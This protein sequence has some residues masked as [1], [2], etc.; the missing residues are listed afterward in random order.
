MM[1]EKIK[2]G[3]LIDSFIVP[4]W[5]YTTLEK[6]LACNFS[7]VVFVSIQGNAKAAKQKS[8]VNLY[9]NLE[10][11]LVKQKL[12][13]IT[14]FSC[15]SLIQNLPHRDLNSLIKNVHEI[16]ILINLGSTAIHTYNIDLPVWTF[17]RIPQFNANKIVQHLKKENGTYEILLKEFSKKN[18]SGKILYRSASADSIFLNR[19]INWALWKA[20]LFIPRKLKEIFETE[21]TD[22]SIETKES[23]DRKNIHTLQDQ[24]PLIFLLKHCF[25]VFNTTVKSVFTFEQ[26]I[27]LFDFFDKKKPPFQPAIFKELIPP[28][29]RFWADPSVFTTGDQHYY[30]FVEEE[31]YKEK[32]AHISVLEIYKAGNISE[33]RIV[34]DKPYHLSYPYVFK[35]G[36]DIYMLPETSENKTIELYRA[37]DFPYKWELKMNLMENVHAVDATIH[38]YNNKYWMFVNIREINGASDW[39]E[40]FLFYADELLTQNWKPHKQNPIVSDV[41]T[42]RPAGKI[43]E[44]E[45]KLYRPSQNSSRS[46]G[47]AININEITELSETTYAEKLVSTIAPWNKKIIATHT[48]SLSENL[49]VI[50]ARK[51][52]NR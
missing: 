27:L 10:R 52:R 15:E 8:L 18:P 34:L 16:D 35:D 26:W 2:L 41:R 44:L 40:L 49:C 30:I 4:A 32:K 5:I 45:G 12:S 1:R 28:K 42:A 13:A 46:Y 17:D 3:I 51:R 7:T 9:L 24:S 21:Q 37:N 43:F 25:R 47:Y 39:D 6:I 36:N 11:K 48:Y 14:A 20:T 31:I 38:K 19:I 33:P 50:D 22:S 23:E 29:D